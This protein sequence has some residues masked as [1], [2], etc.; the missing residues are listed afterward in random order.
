M[1]CP[2]CGAPMDVDRCCRIE[3]RVYPTGGRRDRTNG[4]GSEPRI[5]LAAAG[6]CSACECCIELTPEQLRSNRS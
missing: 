2:D 6:L 4:D 3:E 1:T 5:R